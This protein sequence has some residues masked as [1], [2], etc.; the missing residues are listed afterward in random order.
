MKD[1]VVNRI[2]SVLCD[3]INAVVEN[4]QVFN[5]ESL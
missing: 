2:A 3:A 1:V 4:D 5:N